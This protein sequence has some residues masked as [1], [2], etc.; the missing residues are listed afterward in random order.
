M[1]T[2]IFPAQIAGLPC[3][4]AQSSLLSISSWMC[5]RHLNVSPCQARTSVW[6]LCA[7]AV[8]GAVFHFACANSGRAWEKDRRAWGNY[9]QGAGYTWEN[10]LSG[11]YIYMCI[12]RV[13]CF[14]I[15]YRICKWEKTWNIFLSESCGFTWSIFPANSIV[16]LSFMAEWNSVV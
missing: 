7:S 13:L 11:K 9:S 12:Y 14:N 1:S 10:F 16:S 4:Y 3:W 15:K 6:R 5:P 8:H 2:W